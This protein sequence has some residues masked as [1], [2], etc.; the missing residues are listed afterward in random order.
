MEKFKLFQ[1]KLIET[2]GV[3]CDQITSENTKYG[4]FMVV[5]IHNG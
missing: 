2:F 1:K 5:S 3:S 4:V